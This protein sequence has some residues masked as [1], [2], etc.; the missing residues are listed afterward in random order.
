MEQDNQTNDVVDQAVTEGGS[1]DI[2]RQR[3]VEQGGEFDNK[4]ALLN[5]AR[6]DAFGSTDLSVL[7]R[8]RV[9][10]EHN[11][12]G[13]DIVQVGP[14]LVFGYNVFIGLK[15]TTRIEDVF[16]MYTLDKSDEGFSLNA[17]D[18]ADSFLADAK[19]KHDFDEL[20][21]YYKD[22]HLVQLA[23]KEGKLLA[24]F[25][26]GERLD[27]L[28]V[29]RWDVS[30]DGNTVTYMDNRGERDLDL[31]EKY[32]FEWIETQRDD[33]VQGRFP[34]INILDTIFVEVD[35]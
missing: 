4:V 23:F 17:V 11:C 29:F 35:Q 31:P 26:I 19:F 34:H 10:T 22:T 5:Q 32:D 28:R 2:I 7:G 8:L 25:Q 33:I 24:G 30:A 13:R 12:Q 21:R 6:Q 20:Y 9:R 3:L 27:D 14:Y 1:Y 15:K 16:S 18:L